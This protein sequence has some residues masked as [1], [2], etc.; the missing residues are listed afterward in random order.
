[1]IEPVVIAQ[2]D[3]GLGDSLE[4]CELCLDFPEFDPEAAQLDLIV[5]APAKVDAVLLVEHDRVAGAIEHRVG[6]I[7]PERIG[8]EFLAGQ[9]IAIEVALGHPRT[10]DQQF[11]FDAA[12]QQRAADRRPHSRCSSRSAPRW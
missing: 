5:D 3:R 1:M 8:D 7:L 2:H 11:A 12:A 9:R 10:A 4:P 6:A